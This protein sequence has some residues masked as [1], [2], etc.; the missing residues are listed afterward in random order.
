MT[1]RGPRP[2]REI[3]TFDRILGREIRTP[4]IGANGLEAVDRA[5]VVFIFAGFCAS[6]A[7]CLSLC[8]FGVS[9]SRSFSARPR[10]APP[11]A[12]AGTSTHRSHPPRA[13][14]ASGAPLLSSSFIGPGN[15]HG[16]P[17][18]PVWRKFDHSSSIFPDSCWFDGSC[19]APSEAL[20]SRGIT[21]F[22]G[23]SGRSSAW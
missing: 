2:P 9:S 13:A 5:I 21:S 11:R 12:T 20:Q 10:R 15:A 19:L 8:L 17:W 7:L 23:H 6:A 18:P 4:S 1:K 22:F 16:T 3:V 14:A